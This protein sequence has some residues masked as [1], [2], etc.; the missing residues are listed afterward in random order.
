[1]FKILV[2]CY[3]HYNNTICDHITVHFGSWVCKPGESTTHCDL[4]MNYCAG[5]RN[6]RDGRNSVGK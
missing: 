5:L 4:K 1:M 2:R 3:K 6:G